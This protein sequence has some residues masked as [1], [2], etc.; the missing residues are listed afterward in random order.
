MKTTNNNIIPE[1]S[2]FDY[3]GV[4]KKPCPRMQKSEQNQEWKKNRPEY[5]NWGKIR[6]IEYLKFLKSKKNKYNRKYTNN[7]NSHHPESRV[8]RADKMSGL[9]SLVNNLSVETK[10]FYN[11]KRRMFLKNPYNWDKI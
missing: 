1:Y 11:R 3:Y 8:S 2:M 9:K 5:D 4:G 10:D 6:R 7:L